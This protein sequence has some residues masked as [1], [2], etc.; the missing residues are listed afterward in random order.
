MAGCDGG[1]AQHWRG[2]GQDISY[3]GSR[4]CSLSVE[5]FSF[6]LYSSLFLAS[7]YFLHLFYF[8]PIFLESFLMSILTGVRS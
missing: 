5:G 8:Q 4:P 1:Q 2:G 7:T 6:T 3:T